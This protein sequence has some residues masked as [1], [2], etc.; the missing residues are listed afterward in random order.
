MVNSP[1]PE[2]AEGRVRPRGRMRAA[3]REFTRSRLIDG[4]V[5]IFAE[6]GY[7]KATIDEIAD[8]AGA[9]RAT[10]YLHFKSK[11]DLII[12][13]IG[14]GEDHFHRVYQDLSPIAHSPTT[15][16]VRGW[17]A[18][19]MREWNTIAPFSRPV[20][21]AA[22]I[23]PEIHALLVARQKNEVAELADAL[24]NGTPSLG[25]ADAEVYAS[26]LLAPL[27]YYFELFLRGQ[28]FDRSRVLDVMA[29]TWLAV[30]GKAGEKPARRRKA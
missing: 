14:R 6:R 10:F 20:S 16:T 7:A 19:A 29:A 4:A 9:T 2:A 15:A 5:E 8:R 27:R 22:S 26:V 13:L 24:R 30:I 12:E 23:E 18:T 1:T 11:S 17:L 28:K 3:Q 21:E 25:V